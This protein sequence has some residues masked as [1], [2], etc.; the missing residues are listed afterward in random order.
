MDNITRASYLEVDLNAFEENV[1]EIRK[2]VGDGV[3]I[4]PVIKADGYGTYVNKVEEIIDKFDIVAVA[5][6]DEAIAIRKQGYQKEIFVLNQPYVDEIDKIIEYN[7]T[8]GISSDSFLEALGNRPEKVKVHVEIGTGMGRTGINPKRVEEYIGTIKKYPNIT[9]EGIYTHL[10]SADID[11]EYTEKQ[12]NSFKEA[13]E[14][15]KELSGDTIKYVHASASNGLLFF[16]DSYYNM[17]RPG[18]I[19]YG[20]E[21]CEE[22]KNKMTLHP[23][24]KLR[25][26]ITFLK[27]VGPNTSIGYSRSYI[28]DKDTKV[29][30]IPIGYADGLRRALSNNG[31]V[32]V[33]GKKA[34]IIGNICMDSFMVDVTDI[35]DVKVGD[36]IYV[37]DNN[38][39]TLEEVSKRC[40]TINYEIL[41]TI[42]SR[43]PRKFIK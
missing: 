10:S 21:S 38:L 13:V 27:E 18:I 42:S 24:C 22:T 31:E 15:A 35:E 8:C 12:L 14:K 4:M 3:T 30:T 5:I 26:R 17:V 1:N 43:I 7:I 39:I 32:I 20:Y 23:T 36:P 16:K 28:T 19:L 40:G 25:S 11:K 29:A 34:P 33:H 2:I 9:I 37:W 41:S 6:V